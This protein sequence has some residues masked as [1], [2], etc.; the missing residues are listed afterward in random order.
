MEVT[1][2]R[3][4]PEMERERSGGGVER[5]SSRANLI[6]LPLPRHA[7][8]HKWQKALM[9][10]SGGFRSDADTQKM[11]FFP[12]PSLLNL[13]LGHIIQ[14]SHLVWKCQRVMALGAG[15]VTEHRVASPWAGAL[16]ACHAGLTLHV[17]MYADT[18]ASKKRRGIEKRTADASSSWKVFEPSLP[19]LSGSPRGAAYFKGRL[20]VFICSGI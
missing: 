18:F 12:P 11:S 4:A 7:I 14:R 16:V 8:L 2:C 15:S 10:T 5:A 9:K 20:C 13:P 19:P 1:L 17:L 6:V 3:S